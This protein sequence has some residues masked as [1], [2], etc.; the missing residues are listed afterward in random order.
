M[1]KHCEKS[2][3]FFT[4]NGKLA[5]IQGAHFNYNY[6]VKY[7]GQYRVFVENTLTA[8]IQFCPKCGRKLKKEKE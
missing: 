4:I 7:C 1:C 3:G 6:I 8:S 2:S 5:Y